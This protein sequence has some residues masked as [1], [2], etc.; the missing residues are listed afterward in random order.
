MSFLFVFLS[1]LLNFKK[2]RALV[3]VSCTVCT[4]PF[5]QIG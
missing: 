2:L 4:D 1:L 3:S 5:L